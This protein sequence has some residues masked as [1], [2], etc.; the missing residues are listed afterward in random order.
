MTV[1]RAQRVTKEPKCWE[2]TNSS[3]QKRASVPARGGA[4]CVHGQLAPDCPCPRAAAVLGL[5]GLVCGAETPGLALPAKP[6][7]P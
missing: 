4:G 3:C 1:C 6:W 7:R 5:Q 2:E